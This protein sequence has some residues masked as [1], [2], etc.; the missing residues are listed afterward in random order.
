MRFVLSQLY[1]GPVA[2]KL[3]QP[4]VASRHW[5]RPSVIAPLLRRRPQAPDPGRPDSRHRC[6]R[7]RGPRPAVQDP[8]MRAEVLSGRNLLEDRHRGRPS[9]SQSRSAIS[10][11]SPRSR[12]PARGAATS[13]P[14]ASQRNGRRRLARPP[15]TACPT[16]PRAQCSTATSA[17]TATRLTVCKPKFLSVP[18]LARVSRSRSAS[19]HTAASSLHCL[20]GLGEGPPSAWATRRPLGSLRLGPRAALHSRAPAGGAD[21]PDTID[22][23]QPESDISAIQMGIKAEIEPTG[24]RGRRAC[25]SAQ[26]GASSGNIRS[27]RRKISAHSEDGSKQMPSL[28]RSSRSECWRWLWR[29]TILL[30]LKRR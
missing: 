2:T 24:Q 16:S 26:E 23:E 29:A 7:L 28:P 13:R 18:L 14:A 15:T 27:C 25:V 21:D 20:G 12:L 11:A 30:G 22:T 17:T 8:T 9:R 19:A 3:D 6:R 1:D 5:C 10:S 4:A